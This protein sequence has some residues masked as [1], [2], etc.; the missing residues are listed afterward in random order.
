MYE[1]KINVLTNG[2]EKRFLGDFFSL[3][4]LETRPMNLTYP[5]HAKQ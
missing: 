2:F 5:A 3:Y 1:T 4:K